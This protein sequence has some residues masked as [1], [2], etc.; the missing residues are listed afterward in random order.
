MV[1]DYTLLLFDE[2]FRSNPPNNMLL[3][4]LKSL[5]VM[6]IYSI[7]GVIGMFGPHIITTVNQKILKLLCKFSDDEFYERQVA[8]SLDIAYGSAN[9]SLNQLY[10]DGVVKRRQ[11]GKM[12]FYSIDTSNP[13]VI[14]FKKLVNLL[15]LE[16]LVV[17]LQKIVNRIVLYGS[18]AQ[19]TDTSQSDFDLFVVTNNEE[20][21]ANIISGF[22]LPKGF[23]SLRIHPVIK[24]PIE[25]LQ[26]GDSEKTFIEEVERGIV[27]WEKAADES[28]L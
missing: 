4:F 5:I 12:F 2:K 1:A 23:E 13:A 7:H 8:R 18:C 24:T 21:A 25:L 9:R 16:P 11:E 20:N 14:E 6:S 26:A 3:I 10:S 27:L 28:R 19:G 22:N 15:L 17:T